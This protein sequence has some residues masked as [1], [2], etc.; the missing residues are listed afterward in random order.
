M[1]AVLGAKGQES[2]RSGQAD[3]RLA[4][5]A[6]AAQGGHPGDGRG[7]RVIYM[8]RYGYNGGQ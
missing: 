5:P 1:I 2:P 8:T 3:R 7:G 4:D 6:G